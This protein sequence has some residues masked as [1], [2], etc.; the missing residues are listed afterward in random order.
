MMPSSKRYFHLV[1]P[2][3]WKSLPA[4]E[5]VVAMLPAVSTENK[6]SKKVAD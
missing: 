4:A 6:N 5:T 1:C 3:P 2:S